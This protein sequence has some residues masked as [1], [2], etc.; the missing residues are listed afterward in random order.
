MIF[1]ANRAR[2]V[3]AALWPAGLAAAGLLLQPAEAFA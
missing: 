1:H 3:L 2:A